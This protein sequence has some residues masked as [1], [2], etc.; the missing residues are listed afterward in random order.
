MDTTIHWLTTAFDGFV[1][2]LPKL[3]AGLVILLI[4][5]LISRVLGTVTDRVARRVGFDGFV[6]RLGIGPYASSAMFSRRSP[7][8]W[9]GRAVYLLGVVATLMQAARVLELTF[10]ASGLARFLA[11]VPHVVA[12]TA[13]FAVALFL[14]N[15][16]RDRM[17]RAQ[18]APTEA[19]AVTAFPQVRVLPSLVRAG[20]VGVGGFMALRELQIAPE[21][22]N[23][24]FIVCIGAVGVATA[25]AFGL[26]GREVAGK[27][28]Q[29][30]YDKRGALSSFGGGGGAAPTRT[31][32]RDMW[33]QPRHA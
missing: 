27:I 15:W 20:I 3:V 21:I 9:L 11:Y 14:G 23:T 12:A 5:Y 22:V 1:A 24:A 29:S 16:V 10:V 2:F 17:F 33:Q 30:W 31:V 8:Q 7:S 32:T 19:S 26:G 18:A 28:A 4:G 25:I 13:V 6:G